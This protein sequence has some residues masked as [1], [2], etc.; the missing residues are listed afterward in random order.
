MP[1]SATLSTAIEFDRS[2]PHWDVR[3]TLIREERRDVATGALIY[4][5]DE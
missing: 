1:K 4:P 2:P 5:Y 3:M